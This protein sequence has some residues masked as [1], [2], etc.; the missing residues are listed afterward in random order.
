MTQL[1]VQDPNQATANTLLFDNITIILSRSITKEATERYE[2]SPLVFRFCYD[3][4]NMEAWFSIRGRRMIMEYPETREGK[5][6]YKD[7]DVGRLEVQLEPN[8]T[9]TYQ[10][11]STYLKYLN[12]LLNKY[13]E[14]R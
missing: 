10:Y 6:Y 11:S 9:R 5:S 2:L 7:I 13:N 14:L 12:I 4:I 3:G 1:I 8:D